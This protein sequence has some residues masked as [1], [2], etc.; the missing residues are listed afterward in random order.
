V[1]SVNGSTAAAEDDAGA[2]G[3][4][5]GGAER[6]TASVKNTVWTNREPWSQNV[7]LVGCHQSVRLSFLGC[8]QLAV[9][10][11]RREPC[12]QYPQNRNVR[13]FGWVIAH[14]AVSR[15]P[16][17]SLSTMVARTGGYT[18]EVGVWVLSIV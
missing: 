17:I 7:K 14:A 6:E 18:Y 2:W 11:R 12:Y 1:L 15:R 10:S 5:G 9:R 8:G 16:P 13:D 3:A 4:E